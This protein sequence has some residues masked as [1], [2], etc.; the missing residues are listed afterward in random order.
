MTPEAQMDALA[1][2]VADKPA[3]AASLQS[4]PTSGAVADILEK[5]AQ[6][7]GLDIDKTAL[8]AL[9]AEQTAA[10]GA[11]LSDADL[12]QVA[13]GGAMGAVLVSFV[14]AGIV[15]IAM[16]AFASNHKLDCK[17]YIHDQSP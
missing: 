7:N 10:A 1:R 9:L 5:A 12:D 6:E 14:T 3:L 8:A 2:L 15:C 17:Q 11:K 13:G 4:A 16:S